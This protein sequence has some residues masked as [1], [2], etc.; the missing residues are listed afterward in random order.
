[1]LKAK[2]LLEHKLPKLG[3][4]DT[5]CEDAFSCKPTRSFL[6][7][8]LADGATESSFAKEWANI[9]VEDLAKF[10]GFSKKQFI[11]RL[12]LLRSQ[13]QSK[14]TKTTLPWYAEAK[15]EMGAFSTL[16]ALSVDFKTETYKAFAIGDCCLYHVR[17]HIV[18]LAF[19]IQTSNDF[20]NR[21]FL[22]STRKDDDNELK[23]QLKETGSLKVQKGDLFLLMSDAL[24]HWFAIEAEKN[25]RPW[26]ILLGFP[27]DSLDGAFEDWLNDRRRLKEI[28][29][30]DTTI[31]VI[32]II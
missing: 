7:V 8:A 32:E 9:L 30:D 29:N 4:S 13:W 15:L 25:E 11:R 10:E 2:I 16:L 19:P 22:L 18:E 14:V 26:E 20:S 28:K 21:P 31:I 24:A 5:E 27:D 23:R 17:E 1:M 12:S 6:K 3:N